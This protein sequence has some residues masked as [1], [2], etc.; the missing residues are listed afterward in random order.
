[1]KAQSS[2]EYLMTYGWAI[3]IV[4]MI[5][6]ALYSAG[7]FNL[8]TFTEHKY[9]G[10]SGFTVIDW[11]VQPTYKKEIIINNPGDELTNFQVKINLSYSPNMKP[12][13]SD[14]RFTDANGNDIPYW[15][16]SEVDNSYAIVWVKVPSLSANSS[17]IIY[18]HY[19]NSNTT[20]V[21]NGNDVFLFFDDFR[22]NSLNTSKWEISGNSS[23]VQVNNGLDVYG[24][25]TA[26]I[27]SKKSFGLHTAMGIL[28]TG[29]S[30]YTGFG[31]ANSSSDIHVII[32]TITNN[33][34]VVRGN[35]HDE[36][37]DTETTDLS[38]STDWNTTYK[39]YEIRRYNKDK[40][41]YLDNGSLYNST[42][43]IPVS[44]LKVAVGIEKGGD[45]IHSA[46]KY[47]FVRKIVN[48]SITYSI[49]TEDSPKKLTIELAPK[50]YSISDVMVNITYKNEFG[51]CSY[52]SIMSPDEKSSIECILPNSNS[53][54]TNDDYKIGLIISYKNTMTE[55][56]HTESGMFFGRIE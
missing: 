2:L 12:D 53:L 19:G 28:W 21:S 14:I 45:N 15:I 49:G 7:V 23:E 16:Q 38:G 6:V 44:S 42:K 48:K 10:L 25:D 17:T 33:H 54:K 1:M 40:I 36:N 52:P 50:G 39:Y 43:S 8:K 18:V 22:G 35:T 9:N 55:L 46:A 13:F 30:Y 56:S 32:G 20:N 26:G 31:Y 3:L 27:F 37:D 51:E 5:G 24:N 34:N 41:G 4:I 11:K 47:I 29:K